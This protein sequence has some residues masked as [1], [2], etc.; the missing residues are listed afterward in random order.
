MALVVPLVGAVLGASMNTHSVVGHRAVAYFSGVVNGTAGIPPSH[1]AAYDAAIREFP[2]AVLAGSDMPDFLYACGSYADAHAAGE[3]AHWPPFQAAA[4]RY[5]RDLQPDPTR[6]NADQRQLAAFIFGLSVHYVCDELWEGLTGQLGSR[7][8]FTEMIDAFQLGNN[9]QGNV[10]ENV[11][12]FGGDFYASW[13]LDESNISAWRRTF[14]LQHLVN[15]YHRTPKNGIFTPDATNFTDVTYTSMLE[16]DGLFDLGLWA[17]QTFGPLLYTLYNDGPL[18]HLPYVTEHLFDAPHARTARAVQPRPRSAAP[19]PSWQRRP[20][21]R[22]VSHRTPPALAPLE[23]RPALPAHQP[24]P[25]A[26]RCA[27]QAVGRRR[28]G[29]DDHLRVGAHRPLALFGRRAATLATPALDR[30]DV[31]AS[32]RRRRRR[33]LHPRAAR[34]VASVRAAHRRSAAL[35]HPGGR[36]GLL[37]NAWLGG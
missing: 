22:R 16:C 23:S 35:A 31:G 32:R 28:H 12:N 25:D 7:R 17:L 4:V 30:R 29:G 13:I 2:E 24:T 33:P 34:A 20:R 37:R 9:G 26:A 8:G 19:R 15:I 10:A 36:A 18:H 11:A 14:P 1:A 21:S 6:W 27:A 5:L 3:A